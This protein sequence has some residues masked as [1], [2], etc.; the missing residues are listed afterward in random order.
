MI[1]DFYVFFTL[2]ALLQNYGP[3]RQ[4]FLVTK[5]KTFYSLISI[6]ALLTTEKVLMQIHR[7]YVGHVFTKRIIL[8]L[9]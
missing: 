7:K 3:N 5:V 6:V 2:N 1:Y 4:Y 8:Q 9:N